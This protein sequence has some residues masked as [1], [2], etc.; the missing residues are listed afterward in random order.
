MKMSVGLTP[1]TL[2]WLLLGCTPIVAML[3]LLTGEL[4]M[5]WADLV[6]A[7][8]SMAQQVFWQLRL[9]RLLLTLLAGA[10]LAVT[11][12]AVQAMFRNPLADPSLIGVSAGA[13]LAAV[14]MLVFG[15]S[16]VAWLGPV[17]LPLSAF[18]GGMLVTAL[19]AR[20]GREAGHISVTTMLLAGIA[21]NAIAAS[22]ISALK[23]FSDL[24]TLRQVVFWLMGGLQ[25]QGWPA[26]WTLLLIAIPV[27]AGLSWQGK[28]L[29]LLLLG[30]K[31][32]Q[33]LGVSVT[34]CHRTLI[35]LCALG[36]GAVV[37]VGGLIGFVGLLVPHL[38]RLLVGPDNRALLPLSALAGALLLTLADV[39]AR[40]VIAPAELP[41]GV[42]TALVGGPFFLMMIVYRRRGR[43]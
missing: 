32:A 19:V 26:V 27:I 15:G 29:N 12:A 30:E 10:L 16:V 2:W 43:G 8:G 11:G 39:L 13:G 33:A 41:L 18:V 21:I 42:V 20:L 40:L 6:S 37:A 34:R 7:E 36:V 24:F 25:H 23:Y 17:A 5:H 22:G 35:V 14:S 1:R 38:V 28:V 4:S 9:P 3:A 31:Q